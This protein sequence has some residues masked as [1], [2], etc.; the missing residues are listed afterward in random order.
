MRLAIFSDV[1]GNLTAL[2]AVL[3]DIEA[4]A[5][6]VTIFAGDLCVFGARPAECVARVRATEA[7]SVYGNTDEWIYNLPLLSDDIAEEARRR[8]QMIHDAASWTQAQLSEADLAWL[9]TLPFHRRISPTINPRDDVLVVH[10]NPIDV[11]QPIYPDEAAQK[12][13]LGEVKY[14]Q[15]DEELRPL[16]HELIAGVLAFGHIHFPN[17]RQWRDLTLAN[18]SAVSLPM[19]RDERAKYGLLTWENGRWRIEHRRVAYDVAAEQE[20]LAAARPPEWESLSSRL[21]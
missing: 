10:A 1:H 3:A 18:I 8:T 9:R 11:N 21:R 12:E 2:E 13:R 17:V 4:Q 7:I 16:L 14:S 6:D 20:A 19:D 5:P 15:R